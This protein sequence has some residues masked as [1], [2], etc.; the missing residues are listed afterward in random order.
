MTKRNRENLENNKDTP[1]EKKPRAIRPEYSE[2][3]SEYNS[4]LDDALSSEENDRRYT[5]STP[6]STSS[7]KK[8]RRQLLESVINQPCYSQYTTKNKTVVQACF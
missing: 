8:L 1:L 6:K 4:D 7:A 3:E 5:W 2:S